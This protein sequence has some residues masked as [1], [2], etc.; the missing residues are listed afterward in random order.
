MMEKNSY[1][2]Q[3][4]K[5]MFRLITFCVCLCAMSLQAMAQDDVRV[6]NTTEEPR[7]KAEDFGF[8]AIDLRQTR[9]LYGD[10]AQYRNE[11]FYDNLSVGL[12]WRLDRIHARTSPGYYP[13]L[14]RSFYVSKEID[15]LQSVRLQLSYG[16]YQAMSDTRFMEKYQADLLYSFNWTRYFGGY[17]PYRKI[18][19]VTNIGLGA[20]LKDFPAKDKKDLKEALNGTSRWGAMFIVGAGARMQLSP[21]IS[22]ALEPY[23]ALAS[24]NIDNGKNYHGYDVAYGADVSLAYTFHDRL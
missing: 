2:H 11:K 19:A 21:T 16:R 12:V 6:N 24:D 10:S 9:F 13:E 22:V 17:N 20:F 8:N 14:N 1:M 4:K 5:G 7:W 3:G 18:E 23:A 15:Q